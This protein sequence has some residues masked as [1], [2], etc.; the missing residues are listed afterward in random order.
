ML[1]LPQTSDRVD[2]LFADLWA[3]SGFRDPE[4]DEE[5][6]LGLE[7]WRYFVLDLAAL[8]QRLTPLQLSAMVRWPLELA[9][10][11]SDPIVAA[12]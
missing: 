10:R 1:S 3:W 9:R 7:E 5:P 8:P 12:R 11:S 4:A 2:G 6:S